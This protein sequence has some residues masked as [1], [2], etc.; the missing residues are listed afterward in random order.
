[1]TTAIDNLTERRNRLL[2]P[3]A[4][5]FYDPPLHLVRAKSVWVYSADGREYLDAYNNVPHV[6][7]CHPHVVEALCRQAA[8]LNIHT[9]YLDERIV[10]YGERLTD[11]FAPSLSRAMFCCTGSEA[12]E[13]AIRIARSNTGNTGIIV[14]SCSYHGNTSLLASLTT[15]FDAG[16]EGNPD[17]R[18]IGIPD[19]YR[20]GEL[21]DESALVDAAI[22]ELRESIDS[23]N[24]S[25]R[26]VAALLVDT[27]F[28]TEGVLDVPATYVS[29]AVA[30][31]REAGGLYIADEVQPG[32][33]R[34][35]RH[36][37]GYQRHG[38]VPDLVTL[39]KPMGNGYPLAAVISS[40]QLS[41][42]FTSEAL[43]FNTFGGSPLAAAAGFAVLD[44]LEGERLMTHAM[45]VGDH[46]RKRLLELAD[47][48][49][50]IGDVRGSGLFLGVEIVRDRSSRY[51]A[52]VEC[53][54]IVDGLYRRGVLVS[55]I[56]PRDNVLKIRPPMPFSVENAELL[57]SVLAQT[58]DEISGNL[59]RTARW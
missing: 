12:N 1:M 57:V 34:T 13:L 30:A 26:G 25:R 50:M 3:R 37:W 42:R 27:H 22:G 38:V 23:L 8:Q 44:V 5:T 15:A 35:G 33:G 40:P 6:G 56:G 31:V 32:F 2:G 45:T 51:A 18:V 39:G 28:S 59:S 46:L 52:P 9:R 58:L 29:R 54:A 36:M 48:H 17:L 14:S 21:I 7:H 19:P 41:D 10:E 24:R 11:L 55:R 49:D 53:A 16:E 47:R 43:Y 4:P 20:A